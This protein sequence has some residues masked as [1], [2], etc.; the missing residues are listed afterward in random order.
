MFSS[1]NGMVTVAN[2]AA[3]TAACAAQI[4]APAPVRPSRR[5][6][7]NTV[8]TGAA[9][10]PNVAVRER[11]TWRTP[12]AP[13]ALVMVAWLPAAGTCQA[14]HSPGGTASAAPSPDC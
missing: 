3:G 14:D 8:A 5:T 4:I 13:A 7:V 2:T 6:T 11:Q 1:V 12:A 10:A 9:I